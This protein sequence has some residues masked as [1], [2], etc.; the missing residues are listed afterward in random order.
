VKID[1]NYFFRGRNNQVCRTQKDVKDI[2]C[3]MTLDV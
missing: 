2:L 3:D 1:H